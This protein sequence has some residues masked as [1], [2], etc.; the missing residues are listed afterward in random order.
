MIVPS[1]PRVPYTKSARYKHKS[2]LDGAASAPEELSGKR[3]AVSIIVQLP[4]N[5]EIVKD[6]KN[7][8]NVK[9]ILFS[10]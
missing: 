1:V 5:A 7:I 4:R 10:K 2:P 8:N 9:L 3:T 6:K